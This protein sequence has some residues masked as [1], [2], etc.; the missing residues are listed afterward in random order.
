MDKIWIILGIVYGLVSI[1][2]FLT[3]LLIGSKIKFE[4][5]T[6]K[7]TIL[8]KIGSLIVLIIWSVLPLLRWL[9]VMGIAYNMNKYGLEN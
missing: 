9:L 8:R 2:I 3:S 1:F 7:S 6:K 5:P 4:K